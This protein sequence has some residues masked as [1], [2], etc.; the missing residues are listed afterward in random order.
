M[1]TIAMLRLMV[2]FG[3]V[4]LVWL[5]QLIVYP[6]FNY[7]KTENLITWH[8]KYTPLMGYIVGPLM[9]LQLGLTIYQAIH[10]INSIILLNLLII[11][12]IWMSTFFQ[13]IPI[14]NSISKGHV[15]KEM[16][17]SLV[18]KNWLRTI[19]WTFL[20]ILNIISFGKV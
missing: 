13:F 4:V 3:L 7:Y 2:D 15:S 5:V 11:G 14:H 9:L 8:R 20:L 1:M 18:K 17:V 19:L 16:L 10:L 6:S 12:I